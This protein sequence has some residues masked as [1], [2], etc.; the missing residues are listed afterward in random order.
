[1]DGE[2]KSSED[3][4][5]LLAKALLDFAHDVLPED[6]PPEFWEHMGK[7]VE[8]LG[9]ALSI[10]VAHAQP[11]SLPDTLIQMYEEIMSGPMRV[12]IRPQD[13]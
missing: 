4:P 12:G 8:E 1:M 13:K 6:L 7:G 2:D 11:S 5:H 9:R 3:W 10:Y